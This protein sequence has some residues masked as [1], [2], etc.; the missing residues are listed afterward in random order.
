MEFT[1][2]LLLLVSVQ[3]FEFANETRATISV[4]RHDDLRLN[5]VFHMQYSQAFFSK[6]NISFDLGV[7]FE[8]CLQHFSL[9]TEVSS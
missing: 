2:L 7:N 5:L 8:E 9:D 3:G 6:K 4:T 1:I